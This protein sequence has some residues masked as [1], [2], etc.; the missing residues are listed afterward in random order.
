MMTIINK[1]K[2]LPVLYTSKSECCGCT[3]CQSACA[4]GAIEMVED[5][6]GFDYPIIISNKCIRCYR[7]LSVCPIRAMHESDKELSI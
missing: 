5:E 2:P 7:C 6:K 4:F 1:E 3:A